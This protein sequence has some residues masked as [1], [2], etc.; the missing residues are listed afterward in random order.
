[1]A[2]PGVTLSVLDGQLGITSGSNQN[3]ALW[4]GCSLSGDVETL[5]SFG[6]ATT[7][8]NTLA[9]GE[10]YEA[11]GYSLNVAPGI[12]MAMPMPPTTQGGV[13]SVSHV[14]TGSGTI[15]LS[16]A[17]HVAI[18]ITC[19]TAGALGTAAFTFQLGSGATSAP[20]TSAASW[21]STGY[22]VPG[23]YCTV[24]F[25]AG[26]YVAGGTPDT[27]VIST[28]G[29]VTHPT[30]AGP[31]SPTFT[32]SPVDYYSPT[33]TIGTAGAVGTATFTYALDG[34][35]ESASIVSA[36]SYAIPN[37]GIVLALSGTFVAD[38]TYSF[39][40]AGP[41][42]SSSDLSAALTAL[43]GALLNQAFYSQV[44]VL[45]Q[46]ASASA[47]ATQVATLQTAA[48]NL[49]GN[50]V[51]VTFYSGGPTT[52]SV[53]PNS[54]SITV[55]STDTD[56]VV[57]TQRGTMNAKNVVPCAGDWLM[58]SPVSGLEFRRNA[59]WAAGARGAAVA[60]SEDIGAPADGA[61]LSAVSLYR[62]ENA[63]PGFYAAGITCL[64]TF[65]G[66]GLGGVYIT[67]GL[68]GALSTSDYYALTNERVVN[69]ACAT[70][71]VAALPYINAKIPTQ[72]RNGIAGTIQEL[73][74]Q[75]IEAKINSALNAALVNTN[76]QNAVAATCTVVRTNQIT[77]DSTLELVI[78]IQPFGYATNITI[79]IGLALQA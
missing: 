39:Q 70:A 72:T 66:I 48:T 9:G 76:P 51:Y 54:G 17:P 29:V 5:Y 34:V 12:V 7:A 33:I 24:T 74:A 1:M 19:T 62:D 18:T 46:L 14:G 40:S 57:I 23:T 15:T 42:F 60:A 79:S 43:E 13:G 45:G 31:A 26:S 11:I 53:L 41:T 65:S 58:T 37:T 4:I 59:S 64:R 28:L 68:T 16:L 21:S 75:K 78:A 6:D 49:F 47:W 63:T 56:S 61:V 55:D 50:G 44:V 36:A 27:Y 77:V 35:T 38:D 2:L 69:L 52:G 22:R 3:V 71:R 67:K 32:A 8:S 73:A 25:A 10:L 30:G 20:V